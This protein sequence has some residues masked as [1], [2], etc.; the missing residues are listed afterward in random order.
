M[1]LAVLLA[2]SVLSSSGRLTA[3]S[4][5]AKAKS[6]AA[7]NSG[8]TKVATVLD[9][10]ILL[11]EIEPTAA[12]H[13][14]RAKHIRKH[15]QADGFGSPEEYRGDRLS[16]L[17]AFPL[18]EEY[19]KREQLEPTEAE[20]RKFIPHYR[21]AKAERDER[22]RVTLPREKK[23]ADE[24]ATRLKSKNLNNIERA[25]LAN[26]L[27]QTRAG[28]AATQSLIERRTDRAAKR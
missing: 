27:D 7:L 15:G 3:Q 5:A 22:Y 11:D 28:I 20:L 26:Q 21:E 8:N 14:G 24:L 25:K 17:I 23:K 12:W 18:F 4:T 1:Y 13:E 9:R 19:R 6:S 2:V 16:Q 10:E